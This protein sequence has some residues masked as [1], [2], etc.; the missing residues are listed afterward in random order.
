MDL[1]I[2]G[3]IIPNILDKQYVY[4][5]YF[6]NPEQW[7]CCTTLP[8]ADTLILPP[9]TIRRYGDEALADTFPPSG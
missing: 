7:Q 2:F 1:E 9:H 5:V 6:D 4:P 3:L 8:P